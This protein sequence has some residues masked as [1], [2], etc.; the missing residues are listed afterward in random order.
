MS[1]EAA[2]KFVTDMTWCGKA[3]DWYAQIRDKYK[4]EQKSERIQELSRVAA[5]NGYGEFTEQEYDK[6]VEEVQAAVNRIR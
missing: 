3:P 4:L 6:A 1:Q 5:E 2:L